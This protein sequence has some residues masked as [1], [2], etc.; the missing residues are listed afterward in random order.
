[1]PPP[2]WLADEMV[3][4]LARYLRIAGCDTVYARGLGDAQ[5]LAIAQDEDRILVTRDRALAARAPGSVLVT[6]PR[7]ADQWKTVRAAHPEVPCGVSFVRCTECNGRLDP[8]QP[9]SGIAP[10][11]GIPWDRVA[12]GLALFRCAECGHVYWEG[13]HTAS[14]RAQMAR[15]AEEGPE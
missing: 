12:R 11:P 1:M 6:S 8:Y 9:P 3:G 10:S 14:L 7:L 15:W 2:R 4:R 5:I 13:S